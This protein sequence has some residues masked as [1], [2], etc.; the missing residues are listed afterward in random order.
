MFFPLRSLSVSAGNAL[1]LL[2]SGPLTYYRM[3][4]W[5]MTVFFCASC[6]EFS[7]FAS[8]NFSFFCLFAFFYFFFFLVRV[9][10]ADVKSNK[11]TE[12]CSQAAMPQDG[13]APVSLSAALMHCTFHLPLKPPPTT[14]LSL[15]PCSPKCQS[16]PH[17]TLNTA[18][19]AIPFEHRCAGSQL[20]P[21]A[22]SHLAKAISDLLA[23]A[24]PKSDFS[25]L[26]SLDCSCFL[27]VC[28]PP[29][30]PFYCCGWLSL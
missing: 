23:W 28:S 6:H 19:P 11:G 20:L 21:S 10:V 26:N 24:K 18:P 30:L 27:H 15:P 16:M 9:C 8:Y 13:S 14:F 29:V 5:A 12:S 17:F 1:T 7:C 4:L 22:E 2:I 3:E 25:G